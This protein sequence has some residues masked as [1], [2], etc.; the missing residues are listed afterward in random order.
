MLWERHYPLA[1]AIALLLL[2]FSVPPDPSLLRGLLPNC[3]TI[4]SIIIG[5]LGTI[6]SILLGVDSKAI[7]FLRRIEKFGLVLDYIWK[8]IRWSFVFLILSVVFEVRPDLWKHP[9]LHI[10]IFFG[11]FAVGLTFRAIDVATAVL[12]AAASRKD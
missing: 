7:E 4:G 11:S 10:W 6:A 1:V 8:A 2:S 3:I 5:F 12:R 9:W